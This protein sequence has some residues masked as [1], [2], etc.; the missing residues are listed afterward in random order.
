VL[1]IAWDVDDVLNDLTGAWF[2]A[3]LGQHHACRL[4]FE[5]LTENP[6]HRLLGVTLEEYLA[7]LDAF[8]DSAPGQDLP[9][10]PAMTAWFA[11]HGS[12]C[13][14]LALTSTP[15]WNAPASAAWV[16]RHFGAWVR[17]Y[18]VVPSPRAGQPL[19]R[20]DADKGG[21]LDWL[22]SVDILVDDSAEAVA[23]A[24]ARGRCAVLV[25]RPWNDAAGGL[26][27]ALVELTQLVAESGVA[28]EG[29]A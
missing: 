22:G 26:A 2:R 5:D 19:P 15:L 12:R 27:D 28:A 24:R 1:T 10:N 25:P 23:A 20:Y 11:T 21:V 9:T 13:R 4:S 16:L 3:W 7:S 6:P 14:H 17:C 18:A 8:R 29:P